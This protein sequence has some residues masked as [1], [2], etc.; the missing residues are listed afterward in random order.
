MCII[1]ILVAIPILFVGWT[2]YWF[3]VFIGLSFLFYA[4]RG[5]YRICSQQKEGGP[6][7]V[8][9]ERIIADL[10]RERSATVEI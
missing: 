2:L 7:M 3:P 9:I 1:F 5:I 4:G 8:A 6:E 10:E